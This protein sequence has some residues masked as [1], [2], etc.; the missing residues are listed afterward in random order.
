[1]PSTGGISVT[2][3]AIEGAIFASTCLQSLQLPPHFEDFEAFK[4]CLKVAMIDK[5][6][7]F[8]VP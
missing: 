2:F 4:T 3:D 5:G 1:M 7:D 6:P 8:N